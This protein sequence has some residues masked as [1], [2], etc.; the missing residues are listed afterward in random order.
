MAHGKSDCEE[1]NQYKE[2]G[3]ELINW[4]QSTFFFLLITCKSMSLSFFLIQF[5]S[6][7][8]LL[9]ISCCFLLMLLGYP[10]FSSPQA[11]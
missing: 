4:Q 2:C 6:I 5:H 8:F 7:F 9:I 1:S 10:H 3:E 11:Q